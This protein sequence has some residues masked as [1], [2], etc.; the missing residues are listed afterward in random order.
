MSEAVKILEWHMV[1]KT[2][3]MM[4]LLCDEKRDNVVS[5]FYANIDFDRPADGL[6]EGH[7]VYHTYAICIE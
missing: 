7:I 5:Q 1:S 3:R 6:V 2:S 4:G